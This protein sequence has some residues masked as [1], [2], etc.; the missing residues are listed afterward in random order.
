MTAIEIL[1]PGGPEMLAPATRPV[2][3]PGKGEFW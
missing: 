2:D 3:M 1:E